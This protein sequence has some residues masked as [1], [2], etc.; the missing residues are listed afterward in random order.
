[1]EKRVLVGKPKAYSNEWSR[2]FGRRAKGEATME[3]NKRGGERLRKREK[4][5]VHRARSLSSIALTIII[6]STYFII[7]C[8]I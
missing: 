2:K 7:F 5:F 8:F 1:M 3:T 4:N 6:I